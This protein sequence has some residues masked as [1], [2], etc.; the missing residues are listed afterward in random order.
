[1][2]FQSTNIARKKHI[3]SILKTGQSFRCTEGKVRYLKTFKEEVEAIFKFNVVT[4]VMLKFKFVLKR[5]FV[6]IFGAK[7][8]S[9]ASNALSS[10]TK[11]V[12]LPCHWR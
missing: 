5:L 10:A 11:T 6:L 3:P 2:L 8:S 1:M 12:E 4:I 9:K 7:T